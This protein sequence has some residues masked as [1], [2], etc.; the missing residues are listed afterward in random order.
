MLLCAVFDIT[1]TACGTGLS[2]ETPPPGEMPALKTYKEVCQQVLW[3]LKA[4]EGLLA[5]CCP[6]RRWA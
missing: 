5:L 1:A 4:S 3:T 2:W 6:G